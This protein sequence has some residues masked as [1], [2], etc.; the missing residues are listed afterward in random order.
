MNTSPVTSLPA[1][2]NS[3][4]TSSCMLSLMRGLQQFDVDFFLMGDVAS[5]CHLLAEES[6]SKSDSLP[7]SQ[8]ISPLQ[9]SD[10]AIFIS[11]SA[12]YAELKAWLVENAGFSAS[13]S[14]AYY[15]LYDAHTESTPTTVALVPFGELQN[16][17][18]HW[19]PTGFGMATNRNGIEFESVLGSALIEIGNNRAEWQ[20]MTLP[21]MMAMQLFEFRIAEPN[22]GSSCVGRNVVSIIANYK[23]LEHPHVPLFHLDVYPNAEN[24][25][26]YSNLD[27]L[28]CHAQ[29]IGRQMVFTMQDVDELGQVQALFHFKPWWKPED[30]ATEVAVVKFSTTMQETIALVMSRPRYYGDP[31]V[32]SHKSCQRLIYAMAVGVHEGCYS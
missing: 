1:P 25:A 5:Y 29:V 32:L 16:Q 13:P 20:P 14:N 6:Q 15:L 21:E 27:L 8:R 2:L 18:C 31:K 9:E 7:E 30:D 10:F 12:P 26:N 19:L 11:D 23:Y 17:D 4:A 28:E 3:V 24:A 22:L